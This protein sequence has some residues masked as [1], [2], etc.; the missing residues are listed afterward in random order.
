MKIIKRLIDVLDE[1]RLWFIV[2]LALNILFGT[3]L[4]IID[5]SSFSYIF[6]VMLIGSLIVY[7]STIFICYINDN[8]R[9]KAFN[10]FLVD[11]SKTNEDKIMNLFH[12]SQKNSV[13]EAGELLRSN[14]SDLKIKSAEMNEYEEYIEA[15]AHEIKTP[16]GLMTFVL[17]NRKE[18]LS[19]SVYAKL[20]YSRTK[21]QEN[22]ERMLYYARLNA[23]S[24]DYIFKQLSLNAIC[25]DVINEY[26]PILSE[27]NINVTF[28]INENKI[29]SDQ[30]GVEFIIRQ[31]ISNSIKYINKHETNHYINIFSTETDKEI[32]LTIRDN[33]IGVKSYDLPF[34]FEKG[35]TGE[36][37]EMRKNSTGMGLYLAKQL[38]YSLKIDLDVS[39]NHNDGFEISLLFPKVTN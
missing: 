35:F 37:G 4:W 16:L 14:L 8:K 39:E 22:I 17:D 2:V 29:V 25:Q 13:I 36:I 1:N 15:W 7:C 33:G 19:P 21:I 5:S 32:M 26:E 28:N 9:A 31:I 23:I 27:Q 20:E 24:N 30:K 34:I 11:P 10:D 18:E 6:P 38:S 12:G 3:L